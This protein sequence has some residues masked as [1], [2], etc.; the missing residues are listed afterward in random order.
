MRNRESGYDLLAA[1]GEE[2]IDEGDEV[3]IIELAVLPGE[4]ALHAEVG[5]EVEG[6]VEVDEGDEVVVVQVAVVTDRAAL[7]PQ[8][9]RAVFGGRGGA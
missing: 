4:A 5:A 9:S 6:E 1:A 3:V 2:E 7:A 8:V